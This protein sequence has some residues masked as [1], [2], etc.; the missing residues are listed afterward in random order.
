MG[1]K[2]KNKLNSQKD[3]EEREKGV[4]I[5]HT[6]KRK[7]RKGAM[8]G[9]TVGGKKRIYNKVLIW[10]IDKRGGGHHTEGWKE[11]RVLN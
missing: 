3:R 4:G 6:K 1:G 2:K 5:G 9:K 10:E 7:R 11:G 8:W